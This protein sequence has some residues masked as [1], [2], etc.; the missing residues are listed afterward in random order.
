MS[1]NSNKQQ[2][3]IHPVVNVLAHLATGKQNV[4]SKPEQTYKK[5]IVIPDTSKDLG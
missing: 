2:V 3:S 4:A 5:Y 1:S